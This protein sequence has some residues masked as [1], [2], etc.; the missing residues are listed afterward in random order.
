MKF[1]AKIKIDFLNRNVV[2]VGSCES[3]IEVEYPTNQIQAVECPIHGDIKPCVLGGLRLMR[4]DGTHLI[5]YP[6]APTFVGDNVFLSFILIMELTPEQ[7][8]FLSQV[9]A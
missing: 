6:T 5:T 7:I 9:P 1:K 4:Q 2:V 8:E 3:E